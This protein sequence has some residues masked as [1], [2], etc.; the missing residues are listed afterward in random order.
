MR[1]AIGCRKC[2]LR[3]HVSRRDQKC[4]GATRNGSAPKADGSSNQRSSSSKNRPV[5]KTIRKRPPEDEFDTDDL[6]EEEAEY[7]DSDDGDGVNFVVRPRKN[8]P[9]NPAAG[10]DGSPHSRRSK[11]EVSK[12]NSKPANPGHRSKRS[13]KP[14]RKAHANFPT[15]RSSS[16]KCT[17][18]RRENLKRNCQDIRSRA[19]RS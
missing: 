11:T 18:F 7:P 4:D 5:A 3:S 10:R 19:L 14:G 2:Q 13:R 15:K 9:S 17:I 6:N 16:R 1:S 12:S 8:G